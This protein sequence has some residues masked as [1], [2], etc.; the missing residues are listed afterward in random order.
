MVIVHHIHDKHSFLA[1]SRACCSWYIV[2][3]PHLHH[4][5]AT[6]SW[7]WLCEPKPG[8]PKQLR[9]IHKLGLLPLVKRFP[10]RKSASVYSMY[11]PQN[12]S[13]AVSC[14]ISGH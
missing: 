5:L 2:S 8:W 7:Q 14:V 4:T 9:S 1:C 3:V 13:T 10:V 6:L 11:F 12:D